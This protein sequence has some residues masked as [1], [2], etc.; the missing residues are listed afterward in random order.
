MW[1]GG[2]D[3]ALAVWALREEHGLRP[4]ALITTIT[5][6][7]GRVSMHAVRRELLAEQA[8]LVGA[9]LVEV[10]IPAECDNSL[11]EQRMAQAL[12]S[13]RLRGVGHVAA[14]DLFLQDVRA[15]RESQIAAAGKLALFPLWRRNTSDL[16]REFIEAGFEAVLVCV[17]PSKLD[18][19][20][21]GRRFDADLLADLPPDVDPCGENG[22]FHTFVFAGPIFSR[23]LACRTGEVVQRE[24]FVFCDV[25]A[26]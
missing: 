8:R 18:G 19:S 23:P 11:Y 22:E 16:S 20:F 12:S 15:Y 24:G 14:G 1:S 9:E 26:A 25:L 4:Q 10:A 7:Y 13:E 6:D 2:K 21:A 5:E 17:D 3:S